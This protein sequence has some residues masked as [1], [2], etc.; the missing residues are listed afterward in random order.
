MEQ[1]ELIDGKPNYSLDADAYRG[2]GTERLGYGNGPRP[3]VSFEAKPVQQAA[4]SLAAGKPIFRTI[5]FMRL[6]H[7]GER[8][9]IL[10]PATREDVNRFAPEYRHYCSGRE[11][12]PDGAPLEALF[13]HLSDVVT[14]LHFHRVYTV[15]ML[16]NLTDTQLQNLGM[17]GY[18]WQAKAR[19]WLEGVSKGAGFAEI[20]ER[21]RKVSVENQRLADQNTQLVAQVQALSQ[22]VQQLTQHL[23]A[24]GLMPMLHSQPPAAAAFQMQAAQIGLAQP[25]TQPGQPMPGEIGADEHVSNPE[26]SSTSPKQEP[27]LDALMAQDAFQDDLVPVAPATDAQTSKRR[28]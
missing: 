7:P 11:Q 5:V 21:Q 2:D 28:K 26:S 23:T 9:F 15:E 17:G 3:I 8:D 4:Q 12:R 20:E 1:I 19:R 18:E 24:G 10:R 22:Q 16:A 13:P 14:T 25:V 27:A 6:Q